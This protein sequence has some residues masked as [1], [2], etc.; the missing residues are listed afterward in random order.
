[1]DACAAAAP[2]GGGGDDGAAPALRGAK[3]LL[4]SVGFV[5]IIRLEAAAR[6]W[7]QPLHGAL[8]KTGTAAETAAAVAAAT[9]ALLCR[10][11]VARAIL[12]A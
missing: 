5:A 1:M 7:L 2:A 12:D 10:L 8:L 4:G 6:T 11:A 9:T 3:G